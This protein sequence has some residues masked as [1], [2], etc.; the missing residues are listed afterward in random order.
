VAYLLASFFVGGHRGCFLFL[1]SELCCGV[2]WGLYLSFVCVFF[3]VLEG[4]CWVF[5]V[6]SRVRVLCLLLWG[7]VYEVAG[8]T[9]GPLFVF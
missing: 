7:V 4:V 9:G 8:F 1:S 3:V 5:F 6:C 2:G